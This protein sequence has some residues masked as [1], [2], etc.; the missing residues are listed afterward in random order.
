MLYTTCVER[1]SIPYAPR[2]RVDRKSGDS[3]FGFTNMNKTRPRALHGSS[4]RVHARVGS[5][6]LLNIALKRHVQTSAP[7]SSVAHRRVRVVFDAAATRSTAARTVGRRRAAAVQSRAAGCDQCRRP[8][9]YDSGGPDLRSRP[10][11]STRFTYVR[12]SSLNKHP[13]VATGS[14]LEAS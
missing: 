8:E 1:I 6:S 5:C 11:R 9:D 3:F 13:H 7:G 14:T 2:P 12:R 4:A 10:V